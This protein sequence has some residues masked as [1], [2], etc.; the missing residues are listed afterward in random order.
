MLNLLRLFLPVTCYLSVGGS[1]SKSKNKSQSTQESGT[2]WNSDFMNQL[3]QNSPNIEYN[4]DQL[5]P[6]AIGTTP[7]GQPKFS[8]GVPKFYGLED[9]DYDKL[10]QNLYNRQIQDIQPQYDQARNQT[11]EELSQAG[12]LNSPVQYS[13]GGA[14]DQLQ[15]RYLD[16]TQ[17]AAS[18]ASI[19]TTNLK[20]QELAR[21]TGFGVDMVKLFQTIMGQYADT[22]LRSGQ[23]GQGQSSSSGSGGGSSFGLGLFNFGGSQNNSSTTT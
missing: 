1:S 14:I 7:S 2:R 18:D 5:D 21:K 8:V 16:E 20:A 4:N 6:Q 9:M 13:K 11:R 23:F 12:L 15:Q 22:A 3:Q 10:Q 17:K 19:Q